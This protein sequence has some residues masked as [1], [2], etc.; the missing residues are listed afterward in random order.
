M[1]MGGGAGR[2][3]AG[4]HRIVGS[5]AARKIVDKLSARHYEIYDVSCVSSFL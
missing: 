1:M 2:V 4:G 3:A 5:P